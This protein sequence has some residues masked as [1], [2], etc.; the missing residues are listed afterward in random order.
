LG[1]FGAGHLIASAVRP[2][3]GHSPRFAAIPKTAIRL[4]L[5]RI[6]EIKWEAAV[7]MDAFLPSAWNCL[8]L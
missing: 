3:I 2:D 1:N 8:P 4:A 6:S 7:A 5:S